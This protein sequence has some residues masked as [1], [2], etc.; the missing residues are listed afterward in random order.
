[1]VAA[2]HLAPALTIVRIS[3]HVLAACVWIG[4]QIVLA[5]LVP[6]LRD[7]GQDVPQKVARAFARLSWPAFALLVFTGFWNYAIKNHDGVTYGWQAAF[8]VKFALVVLAGLGA[9]AHS[10]AT[11][12]ARRGATA[13]IGLLASLG[14]MV[15]GVALAG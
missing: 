12:P 11:S 3:L 6:T 2:A 1:M 7:A 10:K 15:L 13:G 14:A 9:Y 8:G 4:G 5:G